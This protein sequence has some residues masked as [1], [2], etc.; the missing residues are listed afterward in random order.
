MLE[1]ELVPV[2]LD[3]KTWWYVHLLHRGTPVLCP[4]YFD[5]KEAAEAWIAAYPLQQFWE[6]MYE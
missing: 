4:G 2:V 1:Y 6:E 5:S 3:D